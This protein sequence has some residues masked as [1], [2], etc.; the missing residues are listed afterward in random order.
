MDFSRGKQPESNIVSFDGLFEYQKW[1]A[2]FYEG[3]NVMKNLFGIQNEKELDEVEKQ[4][5]RAKTIELYVKKTEGDF[6]RLKSIHKHFFGTLYSWAGEPRQVNMYKAG[7]NANMFV[8]YQEIES[9]FKILSEAIKNTDNLGKYKDDPNV[10]AVALCEVY[11][12]INKIH[13]FREGNGRTQNEFIRQLAFHNGYK[14]DLRA[15][16]EKIGKQEY[17]SWFDQ[18]HRT[19][20]KSILLE[21]L[22]KANLKPLQVKKVDEKQL[23]TNQFKAVNQAVKERLAAQKETINQSEYKGIKR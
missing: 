2:Y 21:K 15:S 9:S 18:Y 4:I 19:G 8:P 5:S 6:D 12:S 22:F 7:S 23:N 14:L 13:A 17:Y 16:M 11:L 1:D 20:D 3:S 10:M